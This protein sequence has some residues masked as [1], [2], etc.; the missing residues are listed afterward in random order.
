M[1]QHLLTIWPMPP[2]SGYVRVHCLVGAV[3]VTGLDAGAHTIA[4]APA[5]PPQPGR[6]N[7]L[8]Q[9]PLPRRG[10]SRTQ[11]QQ[12]TQ[13]VLHPLPSRTT[14]PML[15]SRLRPLAPGQ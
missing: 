5:A 11:P 9:P 13:V 2:N 15:A 14:Q 1:S 10:T 6:V 4:L 8:D 3:P 12:T 7:C